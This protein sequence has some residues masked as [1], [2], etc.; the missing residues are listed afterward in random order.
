[1]PELRSVPAPGGRRM[2]TDCAI[3]FAD[4]AGYS[5]MMQRDEG[6]TLEFILAC[7]QLVRDAA[8]RFGGELVQTTGDGYLVLFA[9]PA[10][11]V[12]FG[13]DLHRILARRQ[14]GQRQPAQLRV[15]IHSGR[16]HRLDQ[17]VHRHAV[18]VAARLQ[19]QARPGTCTVSAPIRAAARDL[20]G[21]AFQP[22]GQPALKNITETIAAYRL[23]PPGTAP[24]AG[25]LRIA[26]LDGIGASAGGP[27][28]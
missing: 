26:V 1:M 27:G 3:L 23:T 16:V 9:A 8:R 25:G 14:A 13:V 19:Q 18:N 17:A 22:L 24:A 28:S 6:G 12:R 2:I 10:D 21:L 15:G 4:V 5:A 11:A 20:P 7:S